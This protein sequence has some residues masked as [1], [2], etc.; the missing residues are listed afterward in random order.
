MLCV[1][2]PGR[3]HICMWI[4]AVP[5]GLSAATVWNDLPTEHHYTANTL[6]HTH[7]H[8]HTH[9]DGPEIRFFL[10]T[11]AS[12]RAGWL[13]CVWGTF[14]QKSLPGA[15][16][17]V[18][19]PKHCSLGHASVLITRALIC[20][21][22]TQITQTRILMIICYQASLLSPLV[23]QTLSSCIRWRLA[24]QEK[25]GASRGNLEAVRSITPQH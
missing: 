3:V 24:W 8:T 7:T 23:T 5:C 17:H 12:S 14:I 6:F 11:Y 25:K 16:L 1:C 13:A 15:G 9:S 22:C 2:I 10:Q 4:C 18:E 21:G 19:I 20:R